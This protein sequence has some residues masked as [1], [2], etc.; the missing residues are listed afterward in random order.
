VALPLVVF[1]VP[2]RLGLAPFDSGS[3]SDEPES[4]LVVWRDLGHVPRLRHDRPHR[5][6]SFTQHHE[7]TDAAAVG[8]GTHQTSASD[9]AYYG[10][11]DVGYGLNRCWSRGGVSV[12]RLHARTNRTS[13]WRDRGNFHQR[14]DIR[15][16][17]LHSSSRFSSCH[18]AVL[19]RR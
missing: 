7:P 15:T 9:A 1:E 18:A 8:S 17:S 10:V 3:A 4:E 16:R 11:S 19:Y 6:A 5:F 14:H 13:S 12:S 2:Q